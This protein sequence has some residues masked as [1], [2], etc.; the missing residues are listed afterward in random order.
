MNR[1]VPLFAVL[2]YAA[3]A[4]VR[5]D[6]PQLA[7][8]ESVYAVSWGGIVVGDATARLASDA[9]PNCYQY[10]TTTKPVSF[11]RMMY[12]SP[13][14]S[15]QFCI[16]GGRVHSQRFESVLEGD[17]KQSYKLAFDYAKHLA[18]Q[19]NGTMREI[20][21]EAVDSLSL[22]QAVRIWV[23]QHAKDVAPP[24]AEF[25]MVDR[26]N[27][28]HYQFKLAG[29]E[30][31]QTPAGSFDTLKLERIDNPKKVGLFW[32]AESRD[33]QPVKI[34]TQNGS[35]PSVALELKK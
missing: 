28:T 16:G 29:R 26:K 5:A 21:D 15:S 23:A 27:L 8:L 34:L 17:D 4:Y 22:H 3:G 20:P 6:E 19:D 35:K 10:S 1:F 32:V 18:T 11:V 14:E 30:T 13:N 7:P 9:Q 31:V 33:W 12:G 25:T 2:L 24:I